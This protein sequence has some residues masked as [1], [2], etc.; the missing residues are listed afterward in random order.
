[1]AVKVLSHRGE[2]ENSTYG[3][4][5]RVRTQHINALEHTLRS[6]NITGINKTTDT[7]TATRSEK[8]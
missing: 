3:Y 2:N 4:A 1:M 6:L 7:L 5:K 8:I